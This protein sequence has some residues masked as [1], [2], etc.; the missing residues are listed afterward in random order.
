MN[1]IEITN[2]PN[3]QWAWAMTWEEW[4]KDMLTGEGYYDED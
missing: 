4:H 1:L 2:E 3:I